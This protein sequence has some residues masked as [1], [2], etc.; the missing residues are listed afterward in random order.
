MHLLGLGVDPENAELT[1]LI[2]RLAE[3]RRQRNPLMVERLRAMGV[4]ISLDDVRAAAGEEPGGP[5]RAILSRMHF[6]LALQAKGYVHGPADAFRRYIGESAPA[7]VDKE[8]LSPAEVF[9]AVHAAGGLAAL[10]HPVHLA[11][12]NDAQRLRVLKRLRSDG[13]DAVEVYHSDHDARLTR[14]LLETARRLGLG[15]VGG[16]DF[17][18]VDRGR[19]KLGRPTVPLSAVDRR[20]RERLG[21]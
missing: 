3:A 14:S 9:R 6:A 21:L 13:L 7:F 19:G 18:G 16:S 4:E 20:L 15:V 5:P 1:A 17:H 11:C 2:E 12:E 8:R 10:A